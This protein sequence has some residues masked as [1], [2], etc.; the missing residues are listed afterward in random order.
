MLIKLEHI[1]YVLVN[2]KEES[3]LDDD[4]YLTK[5]LEKGVI[6]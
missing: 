4:G 2:T 6:M 3:Y 1:L 5:S